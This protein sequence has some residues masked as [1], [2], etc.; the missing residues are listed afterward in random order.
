M[1]L[2]TVMKKKITSLKK[3]LIGPDL[4]K[5]ISNRGLHGFLKV[6]D[7]KTIFYVLLMVV[8]FFLLTNVFI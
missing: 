2:Q 7:T 5:D 4:S 6:G 1:S 3:V 8:S